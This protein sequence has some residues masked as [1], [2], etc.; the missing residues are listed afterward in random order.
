M[1]SFEVLLAFMFIFET[2][3]ETENWTRNQV[4][5]GKCL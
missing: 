4:V 2:E 1:L 5:D 3:T